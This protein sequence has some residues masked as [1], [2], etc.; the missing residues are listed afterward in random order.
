MKVTTGIPAGIEEVETGDDTD[1]EAVE[2]ARYD[3]NGRLLSAPTKG[4]NIVKYSDGTVK[5]IIHN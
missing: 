4:I 5:K 3:I 1:A 2:V